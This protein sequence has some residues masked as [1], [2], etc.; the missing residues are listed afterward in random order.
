M[1]FTGRNMTSTVRTTE[2]AGGKGGA[3]TGEAGGAIRRDPHVWVLPM[4]RILEIVRGTAIDA[5]APAGA[6]AER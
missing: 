4:A 1:A 3:G 2:G 5:A 6:Q